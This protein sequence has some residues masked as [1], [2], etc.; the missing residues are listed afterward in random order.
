MQPVGTTTKWKA[1]TVPVVAGIQY[2]F[3][4]SRSGQPYMILRDYSDLSD[5]VEWT[6]M[7]EGAYIMKVVARNPAT[8]ETAQTTKGYVVTSRV[9]PSGS[10]VVSRLPHAL[11]ALYSAGP[12]SLG[13]MR[14]IYGKSGGPLQQAT[15]EKPCEQGLS[16][17]F[18]VAGMRANTTYSIQH[19]LRTGSSIQ[20]GPVLA[21][22][23][24][25][26]PSTL[27]L[28]N[29]TIR[30]PIDGLTSVA[31]SVILSA[32]LALGIR[33]TPQIA[34]DLDGNIIWYYDGTA[35]AMQRNSMILRPLP[36]GTMLSTMNSLDFQ[37]QVLREFD[38]AGNTIR[39]VTVQRV[40][41]Q[42]AGMGLGPINTFDHDAVRLPNGYTAVKGTTEKIFVDVQGP[43][44]V[45]V[46][47][48]MIVVLDRNWQV[49]WAWDSY[50]HLDV[51]RK[52]V[53]G[54]FCKNESLGCPVLFLAPIAK[55]WL[56][57]NALQYLPDGNFLMSLR[58]QD[59]IIKID[60]RD[61]AGTG[62]VIWRLGRDGDFSIISSDSYPWFSHQHD[63]TLDADTMWLYDN[64]NTRRD[65]QPNA[66]SRGMVLRLNAP[67]RTATVEL[68][69][70]LGSFAVAVGSAQR[71]SNG[72]YNFG[73][74]ML[75]PGSFSQSIEVSPSPKPSGTI[76]YILEDSWNQY[77]TF[78]MRDLYTPN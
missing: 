63:M 8:Q 3:S 28:P 33:S 52:S 26:I 5:E 76:T 62:D 35:S 23:T 53:R 49:V 57:A 61:G 2:K 73:S 71:L 36:G 78:R 30:N 1:R 16:M 72:N 50:T 20:K 59:W 64:G 58:H 29:L 7:Q 10:P 77:R 25:T 31:D 34:S 27:T 44:P 37:K 19:E 9:G 6:P 4:V 21:F 56:H 22:T 70:D 66:N 15:P 75:S 68:S 43:G 32:H 38:L 14:V 24:G 47:G 41:E 17:N 65:F 60:Y 67:A 40:S 45:D 46:L 54:E 11:V 51:S 69:A 42:L 55:D 74:G 12:C 39:E 48:A 13:Q 18:L